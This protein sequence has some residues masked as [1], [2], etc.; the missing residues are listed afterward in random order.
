MLA[1]GGK[2][3]ATIRFVACGLLAMIELV[4]FAVP[5]LAQ[6]IEP[7]FHRLEHEVM[8]NY[9]LLLTSLTTFLFFIWAVDTLRRHA[10]SEASARRRIAELEGE[11][12]E[13]DAALRAEPYLL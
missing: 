12:N 8:E 9:P 2:A 10:K 3:A 7:L 11:L 13:A 6:G 5:A 4:S 1:G